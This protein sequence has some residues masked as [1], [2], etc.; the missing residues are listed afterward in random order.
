MIWRQCRCDR[1]AG[2]QAVSRLKTEGYRL[3]ALLIFLLAHGPRIVDR[4]CFDESD[5]GFQT[6]TVMTIRLRFLDGPE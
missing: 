1:T 2:R 4:I 6:V 5:A 3:G